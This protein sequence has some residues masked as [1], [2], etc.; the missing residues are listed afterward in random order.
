MISII[1]NGGIDL[2]DLMVEY[3]VLIDNYKAAF[4]K[5]TNL[6]FYN[7]IKKKKIKEALDILHQQIMDGDIYNLLDALFI[8]VQKID[9]KVFIING[10]NVKFIENYIS[11]NI[12]NDSYEVQYIVGKHKFFINCNDINFS[13]SIYDNEIYKLNRKLRVTWR[14]IEQILYNII[15]SIIENL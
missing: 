4:N 13:F 14:I 5:Y 6:K 2:E 9:R 8:Y 10:D 7:V 1:L 15:I 3:L 12:N 11:C